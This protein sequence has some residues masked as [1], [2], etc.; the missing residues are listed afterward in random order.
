MP[1][2]KAIQGK[3]LPMRVEF[4]SEP[5]RWAQIIMDQGGGRGILCGPKFS[6]RNSKTSCHLLILYTS[7]CLT[8]LN[9]Y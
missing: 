5:I 2:T 1:I 4:I 3:L 6:Y 9:L 8:T 7:V